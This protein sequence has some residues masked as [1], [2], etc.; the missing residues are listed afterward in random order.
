M[1]FQNNGWGYED[2]INGREYDSP[3]QALAEA[4]SARALWFPLASP[5]TQI[6]IVADDGEGNWALRVSNPIRN[7]IHETDVVF[8]DFRPVRRMTGEAKMEVF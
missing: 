7:G 6:V 8:E 5:G 3:E 4:R 2:V 1:Y